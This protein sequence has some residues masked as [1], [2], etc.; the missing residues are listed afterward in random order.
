MTSCKSLH[1]ECS[2]QKKKSQC[3]V[4]VCVRA[5]SAKQ[6]SQTNVATLVAFLPDLAVFQTPL[7]TYIVKSNGQQNCWLVFRRNVSIYISILYIA[8]QSD[9]SLTRN[10]GCRKP[11]PV[12]KHSRGQAHC[13]A[14]WWAQLQLHQASTIPGLHNITCMKAGLTK[15]HSPFVSL[16]VA[17]IL[18]MVGRYHLG[19]HCT[20]K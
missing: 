19:K 1:C 14:A 12:S 11:S 7:A 8:V 20:V 4:Y 16:G 17:F 15:P 5:R 13:A 3:C 2:S 18:Q 9:V 10:T 6:K